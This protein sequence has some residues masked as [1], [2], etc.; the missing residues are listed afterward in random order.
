LEKRILKEIAADS[1][2]KYVDGLKTPTLIVFGNKDRV[3]HPATANIL[4][5]LMPRSEVIIMSGIGHVPMIEQ[6]RKSAG[7]YLKF[8]AALDQ[9]K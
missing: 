7:D 5:K 3:I 1:A 6:P 8:R 9:A 4:H 2:E